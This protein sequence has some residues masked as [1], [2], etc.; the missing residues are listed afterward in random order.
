M[1]DDQADKKVGGDDKAQ[2]E[3]ASQDGDGGR[4][5]KTGKAD[6]TETE[7]YGVQGIIDDALSNAARLAAEMRSLDAASRVFGLQTNQ[8]F[9]IYGG[10]GAGRRCRRESVSADALARVRHEFVVGDDYRALRARVCDGN[11]VLLIGRPGWGRTH[12]ALHVLD[13]LCDGHV[14]H[15]IGGTL[16]DF[17]ADG[18]EAGTG[19]LWTNLAE[20]D[21]HES[22]VLHVERLAE[23][24]RERRTSC[25]IVVWPDHADLPVELDDYRFTL[26]G[27]PDLSAIVRACLSEKPDGST[28]DRLADPTIALAMAGLRMAGDAARLGRSLRDAVRHGRPVADALPK[29]GNVAEWFSAL[30]GREDQ[31]FALSLATLDRLSLPTVSAGARRLD[32]MIQRA[33]DAEDRVALRTRERPTRQLLAQVD[34]VT[35][36]GQVDTEY[37]CVPI[38]EVRSHRSDFSKQ[39]VTALWREFPYLQEIFL[40]WLSD[41]VRDSDPT[42]RSRAAVVVG[43]LAHEDFDFLRSHVLEPW[44]R[45]ESREVQRAAAVAL[46]A[47]ALRPDLTDLVWRLLDDWADV[48]KQ[49]DSPK[50]ILRVT[51]AT[52]LGAPVGATDYERALGLIA[53]RLL[54]YDPDKYHYRLWR[55]LM[56]ALAE[57]FGDG[58]SAQ[59]AGVLTHMAQWAGERGVAGRRVAASA[60]LGILTRPAEVGGQDGRRLPPV[61]RAVDTEAKNADLIAELWRTALNSRGLEQATL[62]SLRRLAENAGESEGEELLHDLVT[63]L[64]ETPRER[65]TLCHQ[66][67]RWVDEESSSPIFL[68]LLDGMKD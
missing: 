7:A 14:E 38:L 31:A 37:G 35:L 57:L 32:E 47:P 55:A 19:Y 12:L 56:T 13:S 40:D 3:T 6:P 39:M 18:L 62:D 51:A 27:P 8:Q 45:S 46:R 24:L 28:D 4:D 5:A 1:A 2:P 17:P 61:L 59:S 43:V 52:A 23:R 49:G 54:D 22:E 15:A 50:H 21:S 68:R 10:I 53:D 36:A 66:V 64:P 30:P 41:L 65:R 48:G 67:Q 33:E 29:A 34:A 20:G 25:M 26:S 16:A 9:N 63:Q 60:L 44:A 58:G 42:V 11:L